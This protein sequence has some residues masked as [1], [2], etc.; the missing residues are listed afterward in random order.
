VVKTAADSISWKACQRAFGSLPGHTYILAKGTS[1]Q[2]YKDDPDLVN[3]EIIKLYRKAI[4]Q[5][6][7]D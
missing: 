5:E 6:A 3:E 1:H 4:N 7:N 2:V